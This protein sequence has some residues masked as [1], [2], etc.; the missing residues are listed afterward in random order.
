MKRILASSAIASAVLLL[1]S[2]IPKATFA[3]EVSTNTTDLG[4]FVASD[5]ALTNDGGNATSNLYKLASDGSVT[6]LKRDIFP[7]INT[8]SFTAN[9]FTVDTSKGK[10]YFMEGPRDGGGARRYRKYDIDTNEFEGFITVSGLPDGATPIN[11]GV[12]EKLNDTVEK[13]MYFY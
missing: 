8:N 13:K 12:I 4:F 2:H 7:D 1:G 3:G 5:P 6:L 11:M 10:I 9:D